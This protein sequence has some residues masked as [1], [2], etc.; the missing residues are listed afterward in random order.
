VTT[1]Q[2]QE[3]QGDAFWMPKSVVT[4][5]NT[6]QM[7]TL[8]VH[9][10]AKNAIVGVSQWAAEIMGIWQEKGGLTTQWKD[11]EVRECFWE[12]AQ[13]MSIGNKVGASPKLWDLPVHRCITRTCNISKMR[14]NVEAT[15]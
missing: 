5:G 1:F 12:S 7:R 3:I 11:N 6:I 15:R 2:K 9:L 8:K 10:W 4:D 13:S 14:I